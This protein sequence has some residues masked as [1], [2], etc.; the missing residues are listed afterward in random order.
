MFLVSIT[1]RQSLMFVAP[2]S[3][4]CHRTTQ[5]NRAT[6]SYPLASRAATIG[7][8]RH[9]HRDDTHSNYNKVGWIACAYSSQKRSTR[10]RKGLRGQL[11]KS[12][13]IRLWTS[14]EKSYE[15]CSVWVGRRETC[16]LRLYVLLPR[17]GNE[18]VKTNWS[19]YLKL[20]SKKTIILMYTV[21]FFVIAGGDHTS[22]KMVETR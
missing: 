14:C 7:S 9:E 4:R 6:C 3:F 20:A 19:Q 16:L 1:A 12:K 22:T 11:E 21:F 10:D 15:R 2:D 8:I 17:G 18:D 5:V 13:L